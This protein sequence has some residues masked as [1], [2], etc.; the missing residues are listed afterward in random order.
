MHFEWRQSLW[1]W[2]LIFPFV[3]WL[4]QAWW[5]KKQQTDYAQVRFWPWVLV[6][7]SGKSRPNWMLLIAWLALTL[8]LAGPRIEL[9]AQVQ[10]DRSGVDLLVVLDSSRS[11][12][13]QDVE[14]NRFV[15]AQ[16]ILESLSHRL[17]ADDRIGLMT[18]SYQAHWVTPFSF[19]QTL[20]KRGLYLLEPNILPMA[21][22]QN[23]TALDFAIEQAPLYQRAPVTILLVTDSVQIE[24]DIS[25]QQ[26][27]QKL[28]QYN[29]QLIVLGVGQT[30]P[31]RLADDLHPS[32]WLH[33]DNQPV[34]VALNRPAL[35]QFAQTT[36]ALYFDANTEQ[37]LM[38]Q[39]LKPVF[40]R[41]EPIESQQLQPEYKDFSLYFALL[42]L[43]MLLWVLRLPRWTNSALSF[44]GLIGLMTLL[45]NHQAWSQSSEHMAY[46]AFEQQEF[47]QAEH[48]YQ[49]LEN[50]FKANFGAGNA[51]YRQT[52][53][54]RALVFYRQAL[55]VAE[56]D[57]R[58]AQSLFNMANSYHQLGTFGFAVESYQAALLYQPDFS[59]AAQNLEL[60]QA[61]LDKLMELARLQREKDAQADE[62]GEGFKRDLD[63]S[64]Y[65]GQAI[66]PNQ[67]AGSGAE[68]ESDDGRSE[69]MAFSVP[70]RQQ[71]ENAELN[72]EWQLSEGA[73]QLQ[74]KM[75]QQRRVEKL[76]LELQGL[77]DQQQALLK[78][79][80]ER[81]AGFQARQEQVHEVPGVQPW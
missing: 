16:N 69:G 26:I 64:F 60:A 65:G 47:A 6:A 42:A 18:F 67:V 3:W 63:G 54:E 48:L 20:F 2:A 38:D 35:Q 30:Q 10:S 46:Q 11:M 74:N 17:Q 51:A 25:Q 7:S 24:T 22:S 27:A 78:H 73:A 28:A 5:L 53:Y 58:R 12:S 43:A 71:I 76:Q 13:A 77:E 39:L 79:I 15:L 49:Q 55:L 61:E 23:L 72:A 29:I 40:A 59:A 52:H 14:P 1:L 41:A 75:A 62:D 4:Y 19:D 32:G 34:D 36:N 21:G 31:T 44:V 33:D 56:D 50:E 9:A 70:E 80:F 37:A 57:V 81:E 66:D 45:P 8:A 68:G